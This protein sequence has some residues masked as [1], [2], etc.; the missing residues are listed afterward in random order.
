MGN[1]KNNLSPFLLKVKA[2]EGEG[3]YSGS[4]LGRSKEICSTSHTCIVH[5]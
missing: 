2:T 1:R 3:V 5:A 4:I